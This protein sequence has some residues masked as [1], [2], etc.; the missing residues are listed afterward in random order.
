MYKQALAGY[1]KALGAEHTATLNTV[2]NLGSL[3]TSQGKLAEAESMYKRALAGYE[4][5]LGAENIMT[6]IPALNT[7]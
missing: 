2:N 6:Y 3:Y 1:E 7:M 5:A 4:K